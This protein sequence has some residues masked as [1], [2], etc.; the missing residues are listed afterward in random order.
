MR[1]NMQRGHRSSS[2]EQAGVCSATR[3]PGV[4]CSWANTSTLETRWCAL[5]PA[6]Y[7]GRHDSSNCAQ[8]EAYVSKM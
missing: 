3:V 2:A 4:L 6:G 8:A 1:G 5:K 7:H